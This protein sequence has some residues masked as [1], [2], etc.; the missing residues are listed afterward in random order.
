MDG[1][2][3]ISWEAA[4]HDNGSPSTGGPGCPFISTG[5]SARDS[6]HVGNPNPSDGPVIPL[7]KK[8]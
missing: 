1:D 7:V 4:I 8:K 6:R 5:P 2:P 3:N